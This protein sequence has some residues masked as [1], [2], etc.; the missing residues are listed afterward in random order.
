MINIALGSITSKTIIDFVD[1]G[2]NNVIIVA[3]SDSGTLSRLLREV[4]TNA[5]VRF[6][7]DRSFA[8]DHFHYDTKLDDGKH[9]TLV[10]DQKDEFIDKEV[11]IKNTNRFTKKPVLFHG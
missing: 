11:V 4:A 7:E 8:I 10:L 1:K 9:T 2:Q 5:G 3:D 6:D